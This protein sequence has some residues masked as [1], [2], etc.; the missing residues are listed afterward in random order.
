MT[1][2]K[3]TRAQTRCQA[4]R[5]I[6]AGISGDVM[7]A[8]CCFAQGIARGGRAPSLSRVWL[9]TISISLLGLI[10]DRVRS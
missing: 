5:A 1:I 2:S 10:I 7:P 9:F 3:L 6:D 8:R 4:A